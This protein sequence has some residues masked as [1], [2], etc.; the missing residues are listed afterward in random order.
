ELAQPIRRG[1][2]PRLHWLVRQETLQLLPELVRRLITP[3]L[4]LLQALHHDPVEIALHEPRQLVRL[5]MAIGGD[6]GQL[7]RTRQLLA[8]LGRLVLADYPPHFLLADLQQLR[9]RERRRSR[10]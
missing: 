5:Q 6:G 8:W 7:A 1:R 2:R 4:L 3:C 9:V 10:Q